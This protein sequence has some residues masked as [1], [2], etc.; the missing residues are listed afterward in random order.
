M[1]MIDVGLKIEIATNSGSAVPVLDWTQLKDCTAMPS[2][3][4]P[5]AKIATD[6][7]GD[8]FTGEMLGKRAV[9]GLDFTFAYDGGSEAKQFRLLSDM[10][11]NN[12]QH[13]LKITYPD[14]TKFE[15]LVECEV[16]LVAPSPSG[17]IDYTL[18][19][20]PVRQNVGEL[21]LVVY[22]EDVDPIGPVYT[23]TNAL[24]HAVSDNSD[25]TVLINDAYEAT[26]TA[27]EDYT[28]VGGTAT[29]TMG[30]VDVTSTAYTAGVISIDKVTGNLVITVSAVSLG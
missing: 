20:T 2:L 7:I 18:S 5:S 27:A 23:V 14:G 6:F 4:Q 17:E 30:G 13:W 25:A 19:V 10:D 24:T 12:E 11:D 15:L 1:A 9:T 3:I 16:T 29:V 28:L 21:I 26:I 22:P 8:E